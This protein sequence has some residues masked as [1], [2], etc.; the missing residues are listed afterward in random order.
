MSTPAD[1]MQP[2]PGQGGEPS[3]SPAVA[4]TATPQE[5]KGE[6]ATADAGVQ[7]A[8]RLLERAMVAHGSGSDK[9]K[10]IQR[11][12][13]AITKAFGATEDQAQ[14]IMPAEVKTALMAPSGPPGGG[15]QSMAGGAP[16]AA[17]PP[18]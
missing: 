3:P 18:G 2:T 13:A 10:S 6:Q 7:V 16:G 12:L 1:Q 8:I 4:P 5:P 15:P 11:A 17:P 9:G 14:E